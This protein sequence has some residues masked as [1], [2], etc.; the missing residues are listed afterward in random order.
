MD[1]ADLAKPTKRSWRHPAARRGC[2]PC[3][4]PQCSFINRPASIGAL[5]EKIECLVEV[6]YFLDEMLAA[7][8]KTGV[9]NTIVHCYLHLNDCCGPPEIRRQDE[10]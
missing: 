6:G 3:D 2:R 8:R 1:S 9:E 5:F 7:L 4:K 10:M